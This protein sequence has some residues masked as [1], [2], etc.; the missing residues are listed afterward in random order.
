MAKSTPN[1]YPVRL[2]AEQRENLAQIVSVGSAPVRKVRH[3]QVLLASD[4][5][6]PGG[7]LT[8]DQIAA[9]LHLHVNTVDRIRRR[10]FLEGEAPALE[11]KARAAPAV[12]PKLDGSGEA[13]L[14]AI[15]CAPAPQGRARWTLSLLAEELV[16]RRVV[17]SICVETVR[18]TLKK[19]SC[20]LGAKSAGASRRRT[21]RGS[22]PK[23]RKSSTFTPRSTA[24]RSR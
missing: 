5:D 16:K 1:R 24:K 20:S 7:T 23:W 18:Q 12:T 2:S 19:T 22:S 13:Q 10:F 21:P 17:T 11:R 9:S 4:R 15:C 8:R 14:V 3:A 6:R